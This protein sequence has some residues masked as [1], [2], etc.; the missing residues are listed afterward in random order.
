MIDP[1]IVKI[2]FIQVTYYSLVYIAGFLAAL[3]L[4][5]RAAKR[6][7]I[8]MSGEEVYD[9]M[10]FAIIGLMI[11]ARVFHILFWNLGYFVNNPIKIFYIWQGGLSFHGGLLGAL[12]AAGLYAKAKK[13][14]FWK[15]AD[16]FA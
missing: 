2:G 7:D 16:L 1:V 11:G 13:I 12:V 8:E 14:N 10:F 5:L 3:L 6:K 4:L 15:I 9:F